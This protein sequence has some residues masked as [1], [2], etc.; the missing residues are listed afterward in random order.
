MD[1]KEA[2]P[3]HR[4]EKFYPGKNPDKSLDADES[5]QM[6]KNRLPVYASSLISNSEEFDCLG[7]Y[8]KV[9]RTVEKRLKPKVTRG[10]FAF[11][12]FFCSLLRGRAG[13]A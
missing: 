5:H 2:I 7:S 4:F 8:S 11:V 13:K 10:R 6:S 3:D 12:A 1:S 9:L